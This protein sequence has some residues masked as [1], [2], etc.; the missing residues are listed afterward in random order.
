MR[1]RT[2]SRLAVQNALVGHV[3]P[4]HAGQ[5]LGRV[6]AGSRQCV[7]VVRLEAL[8]VLLVLREQTKTEQQAIGVWPVVEVRAVVVR[9]HG[10]HVRMCCRLQQIRRRTR[11][12]APAASACSTR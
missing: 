1:A 8:G 4:E 10:P 7:V 9:L 5:F 12:P 2:T 6:H 11:R 3:E